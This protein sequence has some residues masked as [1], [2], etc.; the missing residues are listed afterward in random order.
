MVKIRQ[1]L[2]SWPKLFL[3]GL[4]LIGI[5]GILSA[6]LVLYL[7]KDLP[8][9]EQIDNRQVSQSTKIYDRTGKVLL[10]EISAGQKRTV[11][12][13]DEMPDRLKQATVAVEDE[14][15]YNE[16]AFD[17]K[18]IVRAVLVNLHL[19]EGRAGQGAS[20]ITQQLARNAFLSPERTITRK[21]REL[22]L[23][24][25]LD[26]HYTKDQILWLYL[27][28]IPY[29]STMYGVESA[30][31]A[32]FGKSAKDLTLAE[33]ALIAALPQAPSYYSPWGSHTKDLYSRQRFILKKVWTQG[34]ISEEEYQKALEEKMVF[35]PQTQG[36]KAPHFSLLVQDYLVKK[37]GEDVVRSGG[38][39]VITTL[40]WTLQEAAEKAVREGAERN[41]KLYDGKN[42]ALVAEDPKSGQ[43]L[44]LVGSRDYFDIKNEGNFNA[45]TQGLRQ[46]GSALK[47]FA[48]LTLFKKGFLPET[49][50]FDV[51]MEFVPNNPEC[52]P[53][54]DY[55]KNVTKND[56][57]CFHPQNFD[58]KFR[59]PIALS[60]ALAQSVNI[61][62]VKVLYLAGLE[63]VLHTLADFGVTTLTDPSRYGLS[64]VLG[65]GEVKLNELVG[66]FGVLAAEGIHHDQA[67]VLEVRDASGGIVE[68]Y[69]DNTEQVVEPQ[70]PR[71]ITSILSDQAARSKLFGS[72][73]NL[74]VFPGH[75][76]ALKT[77]TSNDYRDA[78]ALA[79]TPS[80]VVGVWAGN[81]NNTPMHKQGS[82]I[83]AAVPIWSAFM[84]E[85]IKT[86]P[87]ELFTKP[88]P[89]TPSKPFFAGA[90]AP[91]NQ[92]HSELFWV[93][94]KDPSG[95]APSDPTEDP[96]FTNWETGVFSWIQNNAT[97]FVNN[98]L[99]FGG[100]STSTPVINLQTPASGGFSSGTVEVRAQILS[101][102]PLVW[103]TALWNGEVIERRQ[104]GGEMTYALV[105]T[106]VPNVFL[107]QN[108]LTLTATT[109][110][111]VSSSVSLVI[112]KQP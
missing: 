7:A 64:L 82:S 28:E 40:D 19:R 13:I 14:N 48:Y 103:I 38:L 68:T 21:L 70:Y 104:L 81:N 109:N 41:E 37:Y 67:M 76:V 53:I 52:P 69:A 29:G 89:T 49:V 77:G 83:L 57:P 98:P 102:S 42:A 105:S 47:P 95:P 54:P 12:P 35:Q 96:Q 22:I 97:E 85:A 86:Q 27:N 101:P 43:L 30:S 33:A 44:A 36:I 74:T 18:A 107:P 26:R 20:T 39:T 100:V 4:A 93:N 5:G 84:S 8:S 3:A 15:F 79:Y 66:A 11:I 65:G 63:D 17:W 46:P 61:P 71:I 10:Y 59:G 88:D 2:P 45:A 58:E 92:I 1:L 62:A 60:D 106:F 91:A 24:I 112:Y 6:A 50:F 51:P 16:P 111:G 55:K 87:E 34:T 9:V 75:D 80:L 78:W 99:F 90:Y 32:F 94:R 72:S 73:L 23:A 108:N 31:S 25:Y 56:D 110:T